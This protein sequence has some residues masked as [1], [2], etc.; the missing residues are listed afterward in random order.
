M[1]ADFPPGI[2]SSGPVTT[3]TEH[4]EQINASP[5]F[6]ENLAEQPDDGPIINLNFLRYR[7]RQDADVYNKYGVVAGREIGNVGGSMAHH[8]EVIQGVDADYGFS[9]DWDG[10]ALPVYPRRAAYNQMQ[11]SVDY[12][13]AIPDRV[14]GTFARLLYVL[15]DDKPLFDVS[16]SIAELHASKKQITATS[17]D[18]VV[19]ELLKFK[20]D[21]GIDTFRRYTDAIGPLI[22]KTGGTAILSVRAEIPIVS[23]QQWDHFTLIRYPSLAAYEE[24][25]K[26]DAWQQANGI[27][28][29]ALERHLA[30]PGTPQVLPS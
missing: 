10:V 16:T 30:V 22:T 7:P 23:Q 17:D 12:Q 11:R 25:S 15:S 20:D 26:S 8:A 19:S 5:A 14:A 24:L 21:S 27:R 28:M 18:L 1:A 9:S 29:K 6:F 2:V 4:V 13:G 3:F